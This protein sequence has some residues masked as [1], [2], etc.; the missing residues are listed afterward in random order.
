[1]RVVAGI[2]RGR[3]LQA[4]SGNR[5]R[6]T[7]DRVREAIFSMLASMDAVEGASVVD[8]FAG[9]GAL[10]IEALSRGAELAIFVDNDRLARE[11]IAR[12]LTVLGEGADRGR[13]MASDAVRFASTMEPVDLVLADPPYDYADWAALLGELSSRTR[14]LVAE[15]GDPWDLGPAWETLKVKKYGGTVVTVSV[16]TEAPVSQNN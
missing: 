3:P 16:P 12:N 2:A 9:S 1:M 15:T 13:I 5:T 4:P 7:S 11:A 10:G 8:L 14:I 6:P